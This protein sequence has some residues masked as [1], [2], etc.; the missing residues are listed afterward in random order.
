MADQIDFLVVGREAILAIDDENTPH[1][2]GFLVV[3][4]LA[5]SHGIRVSTQRE[6]GE[7]RALGTVRAK[8]S[9][10]WPSRRRS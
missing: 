7:G 9:R 6:L 10:R 5:E 8:E 2:L 4:R 3:D 1:N